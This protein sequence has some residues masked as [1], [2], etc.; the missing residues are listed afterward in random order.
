M[1]RRVCGID[2]RYVRKLWG[3][4]IDSVHK[5][6]LYKLVRIAGGEVEIVLI[7]SLET[8]IFVQTDVLFMYNI[9]PG[10][11]SNF[12]FICF[13]PREYHMD[14]RVARREVK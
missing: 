3:S 4:S 11:H 7:K 13:P 6:G 10:V 5:M 9:T 12:T 8:R 2:P 14:F 1:E